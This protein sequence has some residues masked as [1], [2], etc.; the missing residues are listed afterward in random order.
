MTP[1]LSIVT[2]TYN[3]EPFIAKTIEGVLMQ[4]VKF[5]IELIIAEDCSTDGT[6]V[7]C[8]R[9]AE[10]YP[11]LIRLIMSD[12][13]VGAIANERRAI[14]AA[15]GKYIAFC[16]GDDYW[17]DPYKLQKQVDFLETNPDYSI[18]FHRFVNFNTI[19]N[20]KEDSSFDY[21]FLNDPTGITILSGNEYL[22]SSFPLLPVTMVY[23]KALYDLNWDKKYKYFR[24][25]HLFYLLLNKGKGYLFSF[26]GAVRQFQAGGVFNSLNAIERNNIYVS[27]A[28][29]LY[30]KEKTKETKKYYLKVLQDSFSFNLRNSKIHSFKIL[31]QLFILNISV[32]LFIKNIKR[33]FKSF[34]Q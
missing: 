7:I 19:N 18:C 20:E 12:S 6:R 30:I 26:Y 32:V 5:P 15:R 16:E 9:Y 28:K 25:F 24:D 3:H 11:E 8:Q 14:L 33:L 22:N 13:N 34:L 21:L 27:I 29:D 10:Q 2:I 31:F 23:R 1:L 17:T 4:Q